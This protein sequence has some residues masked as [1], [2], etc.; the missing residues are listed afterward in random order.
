MTDA[1]PLEALATLRESW[2]SDTAEAVM[3][4]DRFAQALGRV[5]GEIGRDEA[6]DAMKRHAAE[7]LET[8]RGPRR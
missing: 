2:N 6:V 8:L 1:G 7:E 3:R 5:L 4:I